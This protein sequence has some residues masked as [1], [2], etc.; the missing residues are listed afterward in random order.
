MK[1]YKLERSVKYR[2]AFVGHD[3]TELEEFDSWAK[4][5]GSAWK[6]A[7]GLAR[8]PNTWYFGGN[9]VL[10]QTGA[11]K[12]VYIG[13][14]M[15]EFSTPRDNIVRYVSDM[16]N[17]AVPYPYAVGKSR[18][19]FMIEPVSAPLNPRHDAQVS[20]P[21]SPLS[22]EFEDPY[23]WLWWSAPDGSFLDRSKIGST[24]A[25]EAGTRRLDDFQEIH[26]RHLQ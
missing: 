22:E 12:Y 3:S 19:Y 4:A 21:S 17:S 26:P 1:H 18:V 15:F 23:K 10:L 9:S 20:S 11:Q 24:A 6:R 8:K 25:K 16:G 13:E 2:N 14:R 5:S 7:L